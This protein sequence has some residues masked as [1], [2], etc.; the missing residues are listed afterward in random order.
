MIVE[1]P[2]I[3][4]GVTDVLLD[5]TVLRLDERREEGCG[6][7]VYESTSDHAC[8]VGVT[9][10]PVGVQASEELYVKL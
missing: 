5:L 6:S 9:K 4:E 8:W 1:V 10:Q 2:V 3:K 7:A